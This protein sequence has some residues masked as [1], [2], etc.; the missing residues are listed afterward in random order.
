MPTNLPSALR[1][2]DNDQLDRLLAAVIVE[3]QTRGGKNLPVSEHPRKQRVK[4]VVPSLAQGKLNAVRA[5]FKVG[6][7]PS[8]IARQFGVSL[9]AVRKALAGDE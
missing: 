8:R 4:E 3:Q 1:H 2:L 6:V 7:R 9:S 5:V